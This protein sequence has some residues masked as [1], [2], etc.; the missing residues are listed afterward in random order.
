MTLRMADAIDPNNL[1]PGMDAYAGY[2]NGNWPDFQAIAAAHG[3]AH[4][5]DLTT[6]FANVGTGED[7]E[8]GDAS[9]DTAP[10]YVQERTA[11]GVCRPVLYGSMDLMPTIVG[12]L[13]KAG[14]ARTAYRLLSAHYGAGEHI[15]GP[16]T[17]GCPVQ[18]D[19]TQWVDHG[20]WDESVLADDFFALPTPEVTMSALARPIV[21]VALRPQNDGYWLVAQ[22]G[23]IFA[24]GDAQPFTDPVVGKLAP[25]HLVVDAQATPSG[26]GLVL[27]ASDGGVFTF[28]D[29]AYKG[30]VPQDNIGPA[31][32]GPLSD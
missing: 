3:S 26:A 8:A 4:L 14:I 15:C 20:G 7:I 16:S 30:S 31:P 5:L 17:C 27:V 19:G 29:A 24:F 11:A 2:D 10:A 13:N 12:Y 32:V 18:C 9:P 28:G 25:G 6:F 22:D 21:A 23:G 1:P